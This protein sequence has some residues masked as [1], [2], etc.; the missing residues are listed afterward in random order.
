MLINNITSYS[1]GTN[2]IQTP[3]RHNKNVQDMSEGKTNFLSKEN[4][5]LAGAAV[6]ALAIAGVAIYRGRKAANIKPPAERKL[7][8]VDEIIVTGKERV[9]ELVSKF[10]HDDYDSSKVFK[11]NLH[12]HSNKSDG[13][14]SPTEVLSQA[15]M[16]ADKLPAGEKFTFSLTDHDTIEGVKEIINE[17]K[18]NPKKY[19]NLRFIPGIEMSTTYTNPRIMS[20]SAD[21]D[22]LIYGFDIDNSLLANEI[23]RRRKSLSSAT[24][25]I[26]DE[27]NSILGKKYITRE[28]L[29]KKGTHTK[30]I[31]SN[32]YMHELNNVLTAILPKDKFPEAEV[33]NLLSKYFGHSHLHSCANISTIDAAK[34]ASNINAFSSIAHPGK[35][36][37]GHSHL[38]VSGTDATNDIISS[39]LNAG[40]DAI[41]CNYMSYKPENQS[42]WEKI[43]AAY[44]TLNIHYSRTG[45][46]DTHKNSIAAKGKVQI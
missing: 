19:S 29:A 33:N 46:Y 42:W 7:S 24:D 1:F 3:V 30:Y 38:L 11:V 39:V 8:L 18:R 43:R 35:T 13:L 44:K 25:K 10:T 6:G 45:G 22:F 15:K 28:L 36:S 27:V 4:I 34:L 12:I 5:L 2:K 37:F 20:T 16:Y 21:L 9:R 17:I 40:A 41:E 31:G 14:L 26:I 23:S 32:G